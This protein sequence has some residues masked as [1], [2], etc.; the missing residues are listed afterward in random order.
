MKILNYGS[1]NIDYVYQVPHFVRPGETL[2]SEGFQIFAGGKGANQ[3]VAL[4]RAGA[5]V[6]HAGKLGKEQ[7]WIVEKLQEAKVNTEFLSLVDEPSGHAIIQV[8]SQGQNAILLHP[9]CNHIISEQEITITLSHF[10]RDTLVLLQNEIN[11]ITHI[12]NSAAKQGMKVC[13]NPAPFTEEVISY[14]LDKLDLLIV[15]ETEGEA[16]SG[17]KGTDDI[18][19]QLITDYPE[20]AIVLTLGASIGCTRRRWPPFARVRFRPG[21][22]LDGG[23]GA[24][25]PRLKG[26]GAPSFSAQ[27]ARS[28]RN[29][30]APA[31]RAGRHS[32]KKRSSRPISVSAARRSLGIRRRKDRRRS[33]CARAPGGRRLGR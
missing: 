26:F 15:N 22:A 9:G 33:A 10:N 20:V 8:D 3:S 17:T 6:W 11:N 30:V 13:L 12:I 23:G 31:G 19:E 27:P 7:Q 29:R 28:T 2:A 21:A 18:L 32:C 4:G 16:L 25:A 24:S 5:P 1:V 14:P